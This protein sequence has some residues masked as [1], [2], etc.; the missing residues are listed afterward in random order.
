MSE[1]SNGLS[2]NEIGTAYSASL[3]FDAVRTESVLLAARET[4][5][6]RVMTPLLPVRRSGCVLLQNTNNT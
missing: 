3:A 2:T 4:D 5:D 1:G 6:V